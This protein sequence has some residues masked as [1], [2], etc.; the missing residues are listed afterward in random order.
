MGFC[1]RIL[2][3][4]NCKMVI[5]VRVFQRSILAGLT[6]CMPRPHLRP[7]GRGFLC[8]P[9]KGA[10]LGHPW[11]QPGARG[12]VGFLHRPVYGE[13]GLEASRTSAPASPLLTSCLPPVWF[14]EP[15]KVLGGRN[16]MSGT[17]P[18][19]PPSPGVRSL[20]WGF[21]TG[22]PRVL[23][24]GHYPLHPR[25]LCNDPEPLFSL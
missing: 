13:L 18:L 21:T 23:L 12:P 19:P 11:G 5:S 8:W 1:F 7:T 10:A 20:D 4:I 9:G 24:P 15:F 6:E 3:V 2:R 14:Q 25:P 16:H 22:A 17:A